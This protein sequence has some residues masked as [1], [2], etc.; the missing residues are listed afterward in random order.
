MT[1]SPL[2]STEWLDEHLADP[3]VKVLD[4]SWHLPTANRN[5]QAEFAREH[6]PSAQFFDIDGIAMPDT[7]L[8]HMAAS[9]ELFSEMVSALGISVDDTI[10]VYDTV[11]LFS[12]ARA[13]W[14]FRVMGARSTFVLDG[15]LPKWRSEGRPVT[16][17]IERPGPARFVP[18]PV[19]DAIV[20]AETLLEL[21]NTG[22]MQIADVRPAAR[23]NGE[24]PEP[25]AG[26]RS[27]H[28]PRALNLPFSALI[29]DGRLANEEVLR[30]TIL[31]AGIDPDK[32]LVTSC[33]SGVTAPLL[34]L[35][36]AQLGVEALSVYDGSWA[37][38][39]GRDDLPVVA[40][41]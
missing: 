24:A 22:K 3:S 40:G 6:I 23:F 28:M 21:L 29:A 17:K 18:S 20:S 19:R 16:T 41:V 4:A 5:P 11:G 26:L 38:W 8:P 25:R 2:V 27:G 1:A 9:P 30:R 37:E 15:G 36:L 32:P 35:A 34:N 33:G 13:W 12:A 39:G 10:I 7:G 31:D 14:N